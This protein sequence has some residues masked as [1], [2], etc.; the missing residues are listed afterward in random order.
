[1]TAAPIEPAVRSQVADLA[2]ASLADLAAPDGVGRARGEAVQ[3][4]AGR[5]TRASVPV[6]EFTSSI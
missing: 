2:S 5:K 3:R 6:A 1:M 4:I